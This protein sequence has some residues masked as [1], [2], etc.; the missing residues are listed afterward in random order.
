VWV[1]GWF[2]RLLRARRTE[3]LRRR[4]ER[5]EEEGRRGG[6]REGTRTRRRVDQ[7]EGWERVEGRVER[8][9]ARLE[10][11]EARLRRSRSDS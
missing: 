5:V 11:R 9:E 6:R 7:E 4:E 3:D 10:L 1:A 2:L 8:R